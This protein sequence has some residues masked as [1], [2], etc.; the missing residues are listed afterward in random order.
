M[1][2]FSAREVG[3]YLVGCAL[4]LQGGVDPLAALAAHARKAEL[5]HRFDLS[6]RWIEAAHSVV[7]GAIG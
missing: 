3:Q 1:C 7:A 2:R 5:L 4:A 6:Y